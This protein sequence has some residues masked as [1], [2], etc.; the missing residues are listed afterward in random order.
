MEGGE[1]K[2]SGVYVDGG[3]AGKGAVAVIWRFARVQAGKVL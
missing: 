3:G 2:E 1:D